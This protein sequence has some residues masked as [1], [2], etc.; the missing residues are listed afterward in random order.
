MMVIHYSPSLTITNLDQLPRGT[1][2]PYLEVFATTI[3]GQQ[4]LIAKRWARK[5]RPDST[6]VRFNRERARR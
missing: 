5:P 3:D 1:G 6:F 2:A 4:V